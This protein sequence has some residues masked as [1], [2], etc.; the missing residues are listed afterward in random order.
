MS[1]GLWERRLLLATTLGEGKQPLPRCASDAFNGV[2]RGD[3]SHPWEAFAESGE[4]SF[5][6][7]EVYSPLPE[8]A[9]LILRRTPIRGGHQIRG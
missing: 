6:D 1:N 8:G 2:D 9:G 3:A 4:A 7:C 5:R